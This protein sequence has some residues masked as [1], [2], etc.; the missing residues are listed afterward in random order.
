MTQTEL[1]DLERKLA[2][3]PHL[4]S[5]AVFGACV[6][7]LVGWL[8]VA[9]GRHM[10]ASVAQGACAGV[11]VSLVAYGFN[12]WKV[13]QDRQEQLASKTAG[14]FAGALSPFPLHRGSVTYPW[15]AH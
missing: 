10:F 11:V 1:A 15:S 9:H 14:Y 13:G 5:D 3:G 8:G 2:Q 12:H 4:V 7:G 6:G